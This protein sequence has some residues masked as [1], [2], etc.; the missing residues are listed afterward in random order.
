MT[1]GG[2]PCFWME[3]EG[4]M[5]GMGRGSP[6][7]RT[8]QSLPAALPA[9]PT[10]IV[11]FSAHW[12]ER[13]VAVYSREDNDMLFDYYGFPPH[14]YE[15]E[16]RPRGSPPLAERC[17]ALLRRAGF[18]GART[19]SDRGLDH[20]VFV[21]L[22]VMWDSPLEG[23]P[24]LQVSLL[25]SMDA[26]AHYRLG[27]A[28]AELRDDGVLLVGSGAATHNLRAM[29]LSETPKW[30]KDF[31]TWLT[32]VLTNPK[33]SAK[34]REERVAALRDAPGARESHPRAEHLL[35]AFIALGAAGGEAGALIEGTEKFLGAFSTASFMW[36]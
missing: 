32:D 35:P 1:H 36:K 4:M 27:R 8:L 12:D 25:S 23:V 10:A 21:P 34:E 19:V 28:L 18:A 16:W 11:V 29:G 13:D 6:L 24:V 22:K 30:A 33:L 20:G 5:K 26:A 15:L 14:T 2:G 17:V 3:D 9:R 31:I 7:H